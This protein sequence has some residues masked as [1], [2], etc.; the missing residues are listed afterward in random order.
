MLGISLLQLPYTMGCAILAVSWF[1]TEERMTPLFDD[2]ADNSQAKI[3]K[4][5]RLRLRSHQFR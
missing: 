4:Y 5:P 3:S 2:Q 1:T